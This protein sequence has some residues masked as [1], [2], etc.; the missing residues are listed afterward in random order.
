MSAINPAV[1]VSEIATPYGLAMTYLLPDY[2]SRF[3]VSV[4]P[5]VSARG[6][7]KIKAVQVSEIAAPYGLAMT[8]YLIPDY[9]SLF[10]IDCLYTGYS[11]LVARCW[12][13]FTRYSMIDYR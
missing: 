2:L 8:Y 3:T 13:L 4:V 6:A 12:I 11:L 1:Q 9:L 10:T 7:L 5:C